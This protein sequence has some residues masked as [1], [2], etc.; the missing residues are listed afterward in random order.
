MTDQEQYD[1]QAQEEILS[2]IDNLHRIQ[3]RRRR[4]L[5]VGSTATLALIAIVLWPNHN[6]PTTNAPLLAEVQSNGDV[7]QPKSMTVQHPVPQLPIKSERSI[8][9]EDH[10]SEEVVEELVSMLEIESA[11][12]LAESLEPEQSYFTDESLPIIVENEEQQ[13]LL[14]DKNQNQNCLDYV[15]AKESPQLSEPRQFVA[16]RRSRLRDLFNQ[17]SPEPNMDGT[18]LQ[19]NI[20]NI[21]QS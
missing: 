3:V 5:V 6:G 11:D 10:H 21:F 8:S 18:N 16:K 17:P 19:I 14:A 2:R 20:T 12:L 7:V 9:V 15:E 1:L 13:P 4:N